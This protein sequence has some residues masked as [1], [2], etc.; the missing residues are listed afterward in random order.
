[1]LSNVR[2]RSAVQPSPRVEAATAQ[3]SVMLAAEIVKEYR[4]EHGALPQSLAAAGLSGAEYEYEPGPDGRFE[5]GAT[6]GT[7]S[8]RYDSAEDPAGVL[9]SRGLLSGAAR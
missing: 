2:G 5:L 9:R 6:L 8:A 7:Q 4:D 1:M 3:V